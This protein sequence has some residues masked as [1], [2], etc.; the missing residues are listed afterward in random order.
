MAGQYPNLPSQNSVLE[1][2]ALSNDPFANAPEMAYGVPVINTN[3]VVGNG[4]CV[5]YEVELTVKKKRHGL[6]A[7]RFE[8]VDVN[9]HLLFQV[10]GSCSNFQKKRVLHDP[11]GHPI[12]TMRQKVLTPHHRW[13]VHRGRK[14]RARRSLIPR[15]AF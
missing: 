13:I 3:T 14:L 11:I 2:P 12:L 8:V 5:P 1:K 4:F 6:F 9:G 10:D 15:A 7:A